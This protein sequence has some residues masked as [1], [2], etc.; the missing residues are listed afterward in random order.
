MQ[1]PSIGLIEIRNTDSRYS[2]QPIWLRSCHPSIVFSDD[3]TWMLPKMLG[4]IDHLS[5]DHEAFFL[6]TVSIT[7]WICGTLMHNRVHN[8]QST[9]NFCMCLSFVLLLSLHSMASLNCPG[10]WSVN[11]WGQWVGGREGPVAMQCV[12]VTMPIHCTWI[13]HWLGPAVQSGLMR[14]G[15]THRNLVDN[16]LSSAVLLCYSSTDVYIHAYIFIFITLHASTYQC[17]RI[18]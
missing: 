6:H 4:A 15:L 16:T 11:C 2:Q 3:G 14:R 10:I 12:C 18:W 9:R 7:W 17:D 5:S 1:P 8:C 13:H